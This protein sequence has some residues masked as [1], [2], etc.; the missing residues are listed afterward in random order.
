MAR[1]PGRLVSFGSAAER[2][3]RHFPAGAPSTS[4][5][6]AGAIGPAA[7]SETGLAAVEP[8]RS[9]ARKA[10]TPPSKT[11]PAAAR[12]SRKK[13][14]GGCS[15]DGPMF[16]CGCG[17]LPRGTE[18]V[19]RIVGPV[20]DH[21][22]RGERSAR[23]DQNLNREAVLDAG[24]AE[25]M[26]ARADL[27]HLARAQA[28]VGEPPEDRP[29]ELAVDDVVQTAA[30]RGIEDPDRRAPGIALTQTDQG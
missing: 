3:R 15:P 28:Q 11:A 18:D 22:G 8:G 30:R 5:G 1:S 19:S 27:L 29:V 26:L 7:T 17:S 4:A 23:L 2:A 9:Q 24:A 14:A 16:R 20:V 13:A 25:R 12:P 6:S 10:S 21:L